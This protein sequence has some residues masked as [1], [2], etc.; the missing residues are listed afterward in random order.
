MRDV[1]A[2]WL[3]PIALLAILTIAVLI[4]ASYSIGYSQ[5][6]ALILERAQRRDCVAFSFDGTHETDRANLARAQ[7]AGYQFVSNE[8][9]GSGDVRLV[10][11]CRPG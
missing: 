7:E 3:V 2:R 4:L 10:R 5:G 9:G 11:L 1:L 8:P 6:Q